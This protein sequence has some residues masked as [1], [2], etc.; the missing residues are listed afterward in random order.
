MI[1]ISLLPNI[2]NKNLNFQKQKIHFGNNFSIPPLH[3]DTFTRLREQTPVIQ[4]KKY[5]DDDDYFESNCNLNWEERLGLI[6]FYITRK[7]SPYLKDN[8]CSF[9]DYKKTF[10]D[11]ISPEGRKKIDS[12]LKEA[13][14]DDCKKLGKLSDIYTDLEKKRKFIT[15][16][17]FNFIKIYGQLEKPEDMTGESLLED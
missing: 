3:E 2:K 7:T 9:D 17:A 12:A 16:D 14:I 10:L 8:S 11:Q 13:G 5:V 6:L 4:E 15:C 1:K